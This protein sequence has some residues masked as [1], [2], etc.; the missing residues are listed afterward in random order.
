MKWYYI[1]KDISRYEAKQILKYMSRIIY[2]YG[3][4]SLADFYDLVG[5]KVHKYTDY[6]KGWRS[7]IGAKVS[8]IRR[9]GRYRIKLPDFYEIL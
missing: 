6:R 7:L 8:L 2:K 4:V 9:H 1:S 5:S 3:Y